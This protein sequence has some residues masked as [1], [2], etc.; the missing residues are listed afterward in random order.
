MSRAVHI[1]GAIDGATFYICLDVASFSAY[2]S[3]KYN[4]CSSLAG[5]FHSVI[6][7]RLILYDIDSGALK[8]AFL[9]CPLI[10]FRVHSSCIA[11][12][13]SV[14]HGFIYIEILMQGAGS[15]HDL[16]RICIYITGTCSAVDRTYISV[17]KRR[18]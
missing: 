14:F 3:D 2:T 5:F 15:G 9:I 17:S 13:Q 1:S 7:G 8:S 6:Y 12:V 10:A 4:T 11:A 16:I 18:H